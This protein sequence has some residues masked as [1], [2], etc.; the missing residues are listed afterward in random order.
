VKPEDV[1][2]AAA[3]WLKQDARVV[4]TVVPKATAAKETK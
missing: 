2:D 3:R 1:R 4:L